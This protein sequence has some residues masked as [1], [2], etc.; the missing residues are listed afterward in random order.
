[1]SDIESLAGFL[2]AS[3]PQFL[4]DNK[5]LSEGEAA[6]NDMSNPSISSADI[7][8]WLGDTNMQHTSEPLSG[9]SDNQQAISS[10]KMRGMSIM[11]QSPL[12]K[13][14][15]GKTAR[16]KKLS[17]GSRIISK[18]K[19]AR[20]TSHVQRGL[21]RYILNISDH[22]YIDSDKAVELGKKFG[23]TNLQVL[24]WFRLA[25]TR[26]FTR[27]LKDGEEIWTPKPKSFRGLM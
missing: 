24:N 20:F 11:S 6:M 4:S 9:M 2:P 19:K 7:V 21:K 27:E 8:H 26:K 13:P 14:V 12:V 10:K 3:S 25:R 5:N 23:I 1:M 15:K 16:R 22:P 18:T 17:P